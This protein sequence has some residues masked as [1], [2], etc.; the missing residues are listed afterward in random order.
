MSG[1]RS[2]RLVL[3][4]TL[5]LALV[6][7]VSARSTI[8]IP[9][10]KPLAANGVSG[11]V[12]HDTDADR[13]QGGSEPGLPHVK[14]CLYQELA[15]PNGHVDPGESPIA[16]AFSSGIDGTFTITDVTPADYVLA[17]ETAT[18]LSLYE[19]TTASTEF[20]T[21]S[22]EAEMLTGF[23]VGYRTNLPADVDNDCTVD[24][25]DIEIVST[26]FGSTSSPY[27]LNGDDIVDELDLEIAAR[28]WGSRHACDFAD[29]DLDWLPDAFEDPNANGTVDPGE[30][31]PGFADTDGD[32]LDDY[33]EVMFYG[34]DPL[35]RDS[36][37][38]G[39]DDRDEVLNYASD[40][41]NADSD[42]DGI[43]D[44]V[45]VH[46]TG[47][48]PVRG[49][50]DGDGLLD[51]V[52]D[53][54]YDGVLDAGETS[55][56]SADTDEDGLWDGNNV[57]QAL[58][59]A[60]AM[61]EVSI[62]PMADTIFG[63]LDA[64]TNPRLADTDSDTIG[65]GEEVRLGTNPL[66]PDT[67]A[68]GLNDAE[69]LSEG[70]DGF[71]TDPK[72]A[73]SDADTIEDGAERDY[74]CNPLIVDGDGDKL[75]DARE[76]KEAGT[77]CND[78]DSD[79]DGLLDGAEVD[80]YGTDPLSGDSDEDKM[81]DPWEVEHALNP[82]ADDAGADPDEDLVINLREYIGADGDPAT[83]ADATDPNNPDT[84]A[85]L[86]SD[87]DE[88]DKY[89][90]KA[91]DSDSDGDQAR[92]GDEV[93][94]GTY[95]LVSD[96]DGDGIPDGVEAA[97]AVDVDNDG[98]ICALDLDCDGD[99]IP[100]NQEDTDLD[101]K[102]A[103]DTNEDRRRDAGETWTESDPASVDSDNDGMSDDW[104]VAHGFDPRNPA[105]GDS[106][107][108]ADG[109]TNTLECSLGSN[110][111]ATDSDGD[112][113]PD[114]FEHAQ[115]LDP[116][117]PADADQDKDSDGLSNRVEYAA[118]LPIDDFDADDDG[119]RDGE[120]L[121]WSADT[122]GDGT[123]DAKDA[124]A[125]NDGIV[126]GVEVF[127][128][129]TS[130]VLAD[131][132]GDT[133]SDYT[134]LFTC[135]SDPLLVDT[136]GD[137]LADD[138]EV[139]LGADDYLTNPLS[140]DTD[141]DTLT[142]DF[143]VT[144]D[145]TRA[146]TD[147]DGADDAQEIILGS[148]PLNPDT[149]ADG[150]ADGQEIRLGTSPTSPDTDGDGVPDGIDPDPLSVDTDRDGLRDGV[151]LV[152]GWNGD[153][154][155]AEDGDAHPSAVTTDPD[156]GNEVAMRGGGDEVVN[157][158][159]IELGPGAYRVLVRGRAVKYPR[160]LMRVEILAGKTPL[161]EREYPLMSG[162]YRW[163]SSDLIT[164][165]APATLQVVVRDLGEAEASVMVDQ[166][167]IA[168]ADDE[169]AF[170]RTLALDDDTDEDGLTDGDESAE[171]TLWLE[172][173]DYRESGQGL[174]A[175]LGAS[176]SFA[177]AT[178]SLQE[179]MVTFAPEYKFL[180]GE[181]QV[182]ARV[183]WDPRAGHQPDLLFHVETPGGA[184]DLHL[185]EI[186]DQYEWQP[187]SD[188]FEIGQDGAL[189]LT[190][191]ANGAEPGAAYLDKLLLVPL[192]FT[193][194]AVEV[195]DPVWSEPFEGVRPFPGDPWG[196]GP[197]A[198]KMQFIVGQP[199]LKTDP[200]DMDTD[201]DGER[202]YPG[203][204]AD[205]KGWL[206]DAF[207]VKSLGTNPFSIDTDGDADLYLW[208]GHGW[209][210]QPDFILDD[211]GGWDAN[212]DCIPDGAPGNPD[213]MPD[214]TDATDCNPLSMDSDDDN[215]LDS[216]DPLPADADIDDDGLTDGEEDLSLN[217][218]FD[219]D[220]ETDLG[221]N[222][223]GDPSYDCLEDGLLPGWDT[224]GDLISD[225]T[226]RGRTEPQVDPLYTDLH[227]FI[228]D[229]DPK[230]TTDPRRDDTD[231]DVITDGAEDTDRNGRQDAG[232]TAS[233]TPDSDGDGL[234]DATDVGAHWGELTVHYLGSV[235]PTDP[236]LTDTDG[237][238]LGDGFE[239]ASQKPT[240]PRDSDT[241]RDGATDGQEVL[242]MFGYKTDPT[243]QDTD[244]DG[245]TDHEELVAGADG[246]LTN[247]LAAD[248][249]NDGV[250]DQ[251]EVTSGDDDFSTDPTKADTDGEG[252]SDGE[253]V[254]AGA[255]GYLT[256]PTQADTD[257]DGFSDKVE[258]D[259]GA[260]PIDAADKPAEVTAGS[261]AVQTV[262]GTQWTA[263]GDGSYQATGTLILAAVGSGETTLSYVNSRW[264]PYVYM[265]YPEQ[266]TIEPAALPRPVRERLM[267]ADQVDAGAGTVT[268]NG[269]VT[270]LPGGVGIDATGALVV[271]L[272]PGGDMTL[273]SNAS[274]S[275]NP[276]TG[277]LTVTGSMN[278]H[279]Q[280]GTW[281][282][283]SFDSFDTGAQ[284]TIDLATGAVAGKA[285]V[286]VLM[287]VTPP[288]YSTLT[289]SFVFSPTGLLHL[290]ARGGSDVIPLDMIGVDND[291][292]MAEAEIYINVPNVSFLGRAKLIDWQIGDEFFEG[293]GPS[294]EI[295][296]DRTRDRFWFSAD[297]SVEAKIQAGG[298]SLTVSPPA[299]G[300]FA[301]ETGIV[302]PYWL[303][304]AGL[305]LPPVSEVLSINEVLIE[306]DPSGHAMLTPTYPVGDIL[307]G[308]IAG[309]LRLLGDVTV[310]VPIPLPAAAAQT[311]A[312]EPNE[313]EAAPDGASSEGPTLDIHLAG[314]ILWRL[315]LTGCNHVLAANSTIGLGVSVA[316]VGLMYDFGGSSMHLAMGGDL[317]YCSPELLSISMVQN[318]I[319]LG[320]FGSP[321]LDELGR[322]NL[323]PQVGVAVEFN[324][325]AATMQLA[326]EYEVG[327]FEFGASFLLDVQKNEMTV[328]ASLDMAVLDA[329]VLL[330]GSLGFD[331][332]LAL[333]GSATVGVAGFDVFNSSFAF[334]NNPAPPGT[335]MLTASGSL[336]IPVVGNAMMSGWLD[337]DGSFRL[338]GGGGLSPGGFSLASATF[339]WTQTQ[340]S[341]GGT[342]TVPGGIGTVAVSG[343]ATPTSFNLTGSATLG[344]GGF[345]MGATVTLN[346]YGLNA[347]GSVGVAGTTVSMA[348]YIHTDGT[349]LLTAST[350]VAL[351]GYQLAS[352]TFTLE[353]TTS[354]FRFQ[355]LGD[356][357]LGSR[358][359][360]SV[361]VNF[362]TDGGFSAG[363]AI[364]WGYTFTATLSVS[365]TGSF[366]FTTAAQNLG[367]SAAGCSL[368]GS[369]S[370]HV[371][372]TD[373]LH[374][375]FSASGTASVKL[376]GVTVFSGGIGVSSA[377][378]ITV[379]Y[380]TWL[381]NVSVTFSI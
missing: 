83:T 192:P 226:E 302:R 155:E 66:A 117:D 87:G 63:E 81:P 366:D 170:L 341:F 317:P 135:H 274:Y 169:F 291:F 255:D 80:V 247:P 39:L 179:T 118:G 128:Y 34:T 279:V 246:Y 129:T 322:I 100:D 177:L 265:A 27:D 43:S 335:H 203:V 238:G 364:T 172:A 218:H 300:H 358:T 316:G 260:D 242:G 269:T 9:D 199:R 221:M 64:G 262:G 126:D 367:L 54:D 15:P 49:D 109:L 204:I 289:A 194:R 75:D 338:T 362:Q 196:G 31:D 256:D 361:T 97:W 116:T 323:Q 325:P 217:G 55:P 205:S 257:G 2:L 368:S 183:R 69:E 171:R 140:R 190:V 346:N 372:G 331:G 304:R 38:D 44:G 324:I 107:A 277:T 68:D 336:T 313:T 376:S 271:S 268:I 119:L 108:D 311:D 124:D 23:D 306:I 379:T 148:N 318:G 73:D 231:G 282:F 145:P 195:G 24:V 146:D 174:V 241:D 33:H 165:A 288:V 294:L 357:T 77:L 356:L 32:A 186:T 121:A 147:S 352:A 115:G 158:T 267:S 161:F 321:A 90:T 329:G 131:T 166:L 94:F 25:V 239:V 189:S 150:L 212:N 284:V 243:I 26:A 113:L 93:R 278:S 235:G 59:L 163:H 225:G 84:D 350:T 228:E 310:H 132:D 312:E 16:C 307:T 202:L 5:L 290:Y 12:W 184:S 71:F 88:L 252:L 275:V 82:L 11:L 29:G 261:V 283:A 79:D 14:L 328:S 106:D 3:V 154:M 136:D 72:S 220:P 92:D 20:G 18:V 50:T 58:A 266:L 78:P 197:P 85:D 219:G 285:D 1:L 42:A 296:L 281:S 229:A 156:F 374:V 276:S 162:V 201:G 375:S 142:D 45:E 349:Y 292:T 193:L 19:L 327:P 248:T 6:P 167:M 223:P 355:A 91:Y 60:A 103:G 191:Q 359:L 35:A 137:T 153:W 157:W 57:V 180:P 230:T 178:A 151:E 360:A 95:P 373:A 208:D 4:F 40:P 105:D 222:Y 51:P 99:G 102:I 110:P 273:A 240:D 200:L 67:D 127:N 251:E 181:Y 380:S 143:E 314:E 340:L 17:V 286:K 86:L 332:V 250:A 263:L 65:D 182:F 36:D 244:G 46:F 76:L 315:D 141:G 37:G 303:I 301:F 233:H 339:T 125:D 61:P 74:G 123:I 330:T 96:S 272:G 232:E 21:L 326:G 348:G 187:L 369:Y 363:I 47:T 215:L 237:D 342:L 207:E 249:D 149:D 334:T 53:A 98:L 351:Q 130:P 254:T 299:G 293:G 353:K 343:A 258:A 209:T 354:N 188:V 13:L 213:G 211:N 295:G 337:A 112:S 62:L 28:F 308:P 8:P 159:S 344:L 206:T 234:W 164:L 320:N 287:A 365:N 305:E 216:I 152:P 173:E 245:I 185:Q 371:W 176:N 22:I 30:S 7:P 122:D 297:L 56:N 70:I 111:R 52:E 370:L 120:E 333:G 224:D 48:D 101:G 114:G 198:T 270:V 319:E 89:L 259:Y 214:W 236:L 104:E 210:F 134:E 10:A 144:T 139:R 264:G 309:H 168:A 345:N 377:G 41:E 227:C 133:L 381:G 280:I 378:K 298:L 160:D 138:E 175:D 253:E 347:S